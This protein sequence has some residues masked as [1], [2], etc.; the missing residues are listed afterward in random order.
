MRMWRAYELGEPRDVMKLVDGPEPMAGPGEVVIEVHAAALQFPDLLQLRGGYQ[1]KPKLPYTMGGEIAGRVAHVGE[2]VTSVAVGDAVAVSAPGGL[3]EL[4]VAKA[5]KVLLLTVDIPPTKAAAMISNY[6][7]TYYALHDRA[8]LQPGEW[9]L[10]HAGAG[11]IGSSA[12]QLGLAAGARVIAT[13]GGADKVAV[14][15]QLGAEVAIDYTAGGDLVEQVRDITG[16]AGVD[17][18]YDPVGGD[19]FDQSRRTVGWNGR[20]LVIGFTSGRIPDAPANHILLKNYSVVG[21]HWG[22]AVAREPEAM[23]RTY[24]KVLELYA[25]GQVDPLIYQDEALPLA[26]AS[27]GLALLGERGTVGKVVVDPRR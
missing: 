26:A 24:A 9:L 20:Y 8:Q 16:G 2:G 25:A 11:G 14:C 4:A 7:T 6:T 17:V 10:V 23:P 21:V 12:I 1:V 19:I 13:A 27:E 22:A 3:A 15:K 18:V 5:E